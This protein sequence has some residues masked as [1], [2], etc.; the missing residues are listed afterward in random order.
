MTALDQPVREHMCRLDFSNGTFVKMTEEHPLMTRDGWKALDPNKTKEE[1]PELIVKKLGVGDTVVREDGEAVLE[2]ISCWSANTP[3]YNLILDNGAHTYFAD[4]FL[5]HNKGGIIK[6]EKSCTVGTHA[7]WTNF[8][9]VCTQNMI[10]LVGNAGEM[11]VAAC[12]WTDPEGKVH[13]TGGSCE[14]ATCV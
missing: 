10:G 1:N 9:V 5:A 14:Y 4:G 3:A 13:S 2:N 6:C 8:S 12:A 11:G 7:D